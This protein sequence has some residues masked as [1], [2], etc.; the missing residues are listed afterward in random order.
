MDNDSFNSLGL[1]G[2]TLNSDSTSLATAKTDSDPTTTSTA[3]TDDVST[4][5]PSVK[6]TDSQASSDQK[7]NPDDISDEEAV[8]LF[9]DSLIKEK[10]VETPTPEIKEDLRNDLK[11]QLLEQ[12]DRSLIGELPDDKLDEL[13]H[14]VETDGQI[15]PQVI[16]K[17]V[18]EAHL[19]VTDIVSTTMKRFR[20]IYLGKENVEQA[21]K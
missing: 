3:P 15:D 4:K 2:V 5:E 13:N 1:E 16:A 12:I 10:G 9:I 6:E 17:M 19:D 18:E 14:I 8:N 11:N 7:S 20:D 21:E